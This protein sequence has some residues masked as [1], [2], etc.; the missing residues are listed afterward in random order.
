MKSEPGV[1]YESVVYSKACNI[2]LWSSKH[3][4]IKK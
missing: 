1:A 4:N 3:V 2:V